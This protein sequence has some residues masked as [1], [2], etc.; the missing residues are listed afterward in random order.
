MQIRI[1]LLLLAFS[2]LLLSSPAQDIPNKRKLRAAWIATVFNHDWPSRSGMNGAEAQAELVQLIDTLHQL[3]MNAIVFQV[4]ATGDAFFDSPI[5]PWSEFLMGEQGKTPDPFFDPLAVALEACHQR[6]ME[7][8]AWLNPFRAALRPDDSLRAHPQHALRK[9]PEWLLRYGPRTY[10]DPGL[11]EVQSYTIELVLDIIRRYDV[12]AVHF[13][14]YFYPYRIPGQEFPDTLS[15]RLH[16]QGMLLADWRRA[17]V[18]HFIE[19]LNDRLRTVRPDIKFGIS[20]FGVWR[21]EESDPIGS[22]TQAGQTSYDDLYA[23]VRKWLVRG[24]IDYVAPQAYFSIGYEPADYRE[25]VDWWSRHCFG[26][27]VY[28][29]HSLY[30]VNNNHDE[31]WKDPDQ[32]L[33]QLAIN[34]DYPEVKGSMYFSAKHLLQNPLGLADSL[35]SKPY[36]YL[37]LPPVMPWLDGAAPPRPR[38]PK[39]KSRKEGIQLRWD[40]EGLARDVYYLAIYRF[41][42]KQVGSRE[43]PLPL[44]QVVKGEQGNWT[45]PHTRFLKR[46]TYVITALD[47]HFNESDA[48]RSV[49]KRRWSIPRK[50]DKSKRKRRKL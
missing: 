13:D 12:D 40:K 43:S 28:I 2:G 31:N 32:I 29:G 24:W 26:R 18:D 35:G 22:A 15:Y 46:Y 19:S 4:R 44:K 27:H 34:R 36:A 30:K 3:G 37:A 6:G 50:K 23:D 1:L 5:E 11:P 8:H 45:D 20:P 9:H 10:F 42:K 38:K 47:R 17:N 33:Q 25:L 48:A 16:G 7:L 49:T 21:N 14:D 39:A 41:P